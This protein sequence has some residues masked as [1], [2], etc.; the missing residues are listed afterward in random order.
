MKILM[1]EILKENNVWWENCLMNELFNDRN[2]ERDEWD[3]FLN[4]E[5]FRRW[6]C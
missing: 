2:V 6:K 5:I 3:N 1:K 4:N